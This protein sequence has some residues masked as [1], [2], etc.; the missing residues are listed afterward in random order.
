[1]DTALDKW[2]GEFGSSCLGQKKEDLYGEF[3]SRVFTN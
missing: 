1:V 3:R 2:K